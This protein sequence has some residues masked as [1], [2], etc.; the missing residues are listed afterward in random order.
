RRFGTMRTLSGTRYRAPQEE[1]MMTVAAV[2]IA[3]DLFSA[4]RTQDLN[5]VEKLLSQDSSL[6]A[7]KDENGSSPIGAALGARKGEGFVP[8][9]ENRVLDAILRRDPPL[10]P[11]EV[12]AVGSAAQVRAEMARSPEFVRAVS[13]NGWT[14]L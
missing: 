7:K 4:I 3:A 6:A 14:P 11:Q 5:E 9:R 13:R 8:R 1:I 12:A 10:S 2:L